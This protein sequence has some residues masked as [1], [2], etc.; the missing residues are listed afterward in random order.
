ML[1]EVWQATVHMVTE[2]NTTERL[3]PSDGTNSTTYNF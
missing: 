3:T 1:R 2:S